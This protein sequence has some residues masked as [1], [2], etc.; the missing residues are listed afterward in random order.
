MKGKRKTTPSPRQPHLRRSRELGAALFSVVR[1]K[2]VGRG[3]VI[4]SSSALA[5]KLNAPPRVT[6]TQHAEGG[7]EL[8]WQKK[9]PEVLTVVVYDDTLLNKTP[10]YIYFFSPPIPGGESPFFFFSF[11]SFS[12]LSSATG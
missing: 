11:L 9:T 6:Y 12:P 1:T 10:V 7:R 8:R 2:T 5:K 3:D 4:L